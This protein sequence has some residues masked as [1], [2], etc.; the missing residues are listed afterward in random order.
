[1]EQEKGVVKH[2]V[3]AKFK[4]GISQKQVDELIK[5]Y[6]NL[7]NLTEPMKSFQW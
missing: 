2:V 7:V 1:M 6:A 5:A 4:E 3:V